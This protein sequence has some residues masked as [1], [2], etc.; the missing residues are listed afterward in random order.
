MKIM[1]SNFIKNKGSFSTLI[2][3]SALLLMQSCNKFLNVSPTDV[4]REQ[5]FLT[6]YW[7]AQFMLRGMYQAMQPVVV[8]KFILGEV[9]ADW[10]KPG[11]GADSNIVQLAEHRVTPN[12]TYTQWG[13]YYDL[14]N[15]ANY[16]I[17]NIPRVPRDQN[18]F[19]EFMMNQYIGEAKFLRAFAYFNL[20]ENWG[21]VPYTT[22]AVDNINAVQYLSTTPQ[23]AILDS[24]E[25][26]L[27]DAFVKTDYVIMVYN[28]DGTL[29]QSV[30]QTQH[31]VCKGTV[32]ALQAEVYLWRNKYSQAVAAC[33]AWQNTG[34]YPYILN[35]N[36][37]WF[38]IFGTTDIIY[39]EP[40]FLV[41]F[42]FA[43][44]ENSPM[45]TLTSNDP[46]SGGKY[47]VAPSDV[48]IKTYNPN[49]PYFVSTTDNTSDEIYRGFGNSYAGSAPFYN[50]VG[51]SPVIWKYIG[52]GTVL[53]ATID[54]PASV[55]LPYQSDA[56]FHVYREADM[57]LLWAEALNRNG[58]KTNAIAKINTVRSR[59]G[60]LPANTT[61]TLK[62]IPTV[63]TAST[64]EQIEDFILRER[65]LELGFEGRRWY[66][67]MRIARHGRP[68]VLINAV[69]SRASA[70]LTP[71]LEA[72][73]TNTNNWV[74]PYNANE[75]A[76]DP[77][78]HQH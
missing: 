15:R 48:A 37:S 23:D 19:S 67:L 25:T 73:L 50:R 55:E 20:V 39:N 14:I 54:V 77:N 21:D 3:L 41:S 9:Q 61:T 2:L 12:N 72:T 43:T 36:S 46:A 35:N 22:Q 75:L 69:E 65:G 60:M 76:L 52:T 66:D 31:R 4:T 11:T 51:S 34:N 6:N 57:F 24:I 59:A 7:D 10:V 16:L 18:N 70:T 27:A 71:Y 44:R 30:E 49:W 38:K 47:V 40:M 33:Q 29:R 17:K 78:L 56:T 68:R 1:K 64:T 74:L 13:C 63:T 58:D 62:G 32:C 5:D 45:M 26:D 42:I 53:P 8:N 28:E